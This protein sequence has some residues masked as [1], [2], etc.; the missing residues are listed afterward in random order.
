MPSE[1]K[2]TPDENSKSAQII[3]ET[4]DSA[5]ISNDGAVPADEQKK[6][7]KRKKRIFT[8]HDQQRM[9]QALGRIEGRIVPAGSGIEIATDDGAAFR[10]S[11]MGKPGLAV[12][13]LGLSD[14]QRF[15]KF[16]FWPAFIKDGII[17]VSFNNADDWEP[18]ENSPPVDR[19]FLCG[20]LQEVESNRFSVLVGY[21]RRKKNERV[22]RLLTV[23]STP[24]PEWK[25]G[26]WVDLVLHRQGQ[27]WQWHGDFHPRGP[28]VGGGFNSWLPYKEAKSA[29][30]QQEGATSQRRNE[31]A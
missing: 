5:V 18:Q 19:M 6:R 24:R 15:G 23:E 9:V 13:L 20:T 2:Q 30:V 22:D 27:D 26:D 28:Q 1:T 31:E 11:G 12:R 25:A 14:N 21:L 3:S 8:P 4:Q 7:K 17:L 16:A 29:D 10:V